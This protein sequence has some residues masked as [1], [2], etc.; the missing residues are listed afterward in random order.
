MDRHPEIIIDSCPGLVFIIDPAGRLLFLN[1]AVG[2]YG[3]SPADLIGE[4]ASRLLCDWG[5]DN[6]PAPLP[7][8]VQSGK[9]LRLETKSGDIVRAVF[10]LFPLVKPGGETIGTAGIEGAAELSGLRPGEGYPPPAGLPHEIKSPL[11]ALELGLSIL[12]RTAGEEDK[13][14]LEILTRKLS[15]LQRVVLGLL[16]LVEEKEMAD[17]RK[18]PDHR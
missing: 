3:Y 1:R 2:K 5:S 4:E 10:N 13:P 8:R 9:Y 6:L 16:E 15:Q 11:A 17:G 14:V 12:K 18:D 7:G